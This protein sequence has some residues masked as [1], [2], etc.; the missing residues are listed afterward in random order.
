MK[1]GVR[2]VVRCG[3]GSARR[4]RKGR[5]RSACKEGDRRRAAVGV[6]EKIGRFSFHTHAI[7]ISTPVLGAGPSDV[8]KGIQSSGVERYSHKLEA[9]EPKDNCGAPH[10]AH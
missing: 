8:R 9:D 2:G 5:Q 10:E 6:Q 7:S 1:C 4:L 3:V